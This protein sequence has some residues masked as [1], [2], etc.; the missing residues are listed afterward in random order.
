MEDQGISD[1]HRAALIERLMKDKQLRLS[2]IFAH[3]ASTNLR[4]SFWDIEWQ[5]WMYGINLPEGSW[6][7]P[8]KLPRK[9]GDF[10]DRDRI[11]LSKALKKSYA[12]RVGVRSLGKPYRFYYQPA[13]GRQ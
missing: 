7:S 12:A 8:H 3:Y 13:L 9:M 5:E 11:L 2:E 1:S 10:V 6:K 4:S